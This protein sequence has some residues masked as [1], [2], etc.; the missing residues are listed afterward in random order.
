MAYFR[1]Y[2]SAFGRWHFPLASHASFYFLMVPEKHFARSP[3]INQALRGGLNI[4]APP[5]GRT[6]DV[7]AQ[8]LPGDRY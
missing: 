8:V 3:A 2:V 1:G 4:I 5:L 7:R 6:A